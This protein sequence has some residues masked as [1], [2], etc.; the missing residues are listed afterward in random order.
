MFADQISFVRPINCLNI[1]IQNL[2]F[3]FATNYQI[4]I[5]AALFYFILI[6]FY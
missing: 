2:G 1:P 3:S 4:V 5:T 6:I